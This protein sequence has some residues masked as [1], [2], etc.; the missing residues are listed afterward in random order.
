MEWSGFYAR[1]RRHRIPLPTYPFERQRYWVEPQKREYDVNTPQGSL[2]KEPDIADWFYIPSW[3]RSVTPQL[4]DQG[5]LAD[6]KLCWLVF[7]DA[8]GLGAQMVERL[9]QQDQDVITVTAGEQFSRVNNGVYTI[10]PRQRD[11]L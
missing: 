6:Q 7:I 5:D 3:K 8:C 11:A 9:E 1:E 4:F 10:N 2:R